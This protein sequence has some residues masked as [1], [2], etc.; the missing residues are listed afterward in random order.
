[1]PC[2]MQDLSSLTRDQIRVSTME[3]QSLNHWTSREVPSLANF[4]ILKAGA[5]IRFLSNFI[6]GD[7][8]KTCVHIQ[9]QVVSSNCVSR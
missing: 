8:N 2:S 6:G 5:V 9:L 7:H 3:E 1:M 4:F